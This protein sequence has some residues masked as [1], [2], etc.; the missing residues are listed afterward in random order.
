MTPRISPL[1]DQPA[2]ASVLIDVDKLA[3]AGRWHVARPSSTEDVHKIYAESFQGV[4]Q[5]LRIL[6]QA[7]ATVDAALVPAMNKEPT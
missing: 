6:A 7:Q 3:A 4:V 1:A 5:L 2:P